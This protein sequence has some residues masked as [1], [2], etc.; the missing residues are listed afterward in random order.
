[1]ILLPFL[2]RLTPA[3]ASRRRE[4]GNTESVGNAWDINRQPGERSG[5]WIPAFAGMTTEQYH[6]A[7]AG[8][9]EIYMLYQCLNKDYP[10]LTAGCVENM[11]RP[12]S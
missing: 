1:M 7:P 2:L 8:G 6:Q 5:I 11:V 3:E 4:S 10:P 9:T 12:V